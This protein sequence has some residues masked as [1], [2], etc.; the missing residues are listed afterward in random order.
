MRGINII[1]VF[2][3]TSEA[4]TAFVRSARRSLRLDGRR[5]IAPT[6]APTRYPPDPPRIVR[7]SSVLTP[8]LP[9]LPK[10]WGNLGM[11]PLGP[12]VFHSGVNPTDATGFTP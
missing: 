7:T 3:R 12:L 5:Q 1:R 4:S 6:A 10:A 8:F 9:D 11:T 2:V